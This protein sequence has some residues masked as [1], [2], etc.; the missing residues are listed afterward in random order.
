MRDLKLAVALIRA[1]PDQPH[2]LGRRRLLNNPQTKESRQQIDFIM[3]D[4]IDAE[5]VRTAVAREVSWVLDIDRD[6]DLLVSN[7][8]QLNIQFEGVMP[9]TT[10][11]CQVTA[12]FYNV[13][14]YR[15]AA[16]ER[17]SASD[18]FVWLS[19]HEICSG[20]SDEGIEIDPVFL[21]LNRQAN[22][23]Q[24]WESDALS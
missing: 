19:S 15:S 6:R 3:T 24:S 7:M 18:D 9:G 17:I 8:A 10:E 14:F 4:A 22:V 23:I 1:R 11:R 2:W 5:S 12:A 21:W 13:N 16:I 20:R